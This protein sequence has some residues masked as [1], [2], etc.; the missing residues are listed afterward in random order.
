MKKILYT[1]NKLV[2]LFA[3]PA[4]LF[5]CNDY[6][7]EM[8]DNRTELDTPQKIT[9]ILVSAY[10]Q[11]LPVAMQELMSD[12]V[13]DYG[14]S[15]D[16]YRD[17]FQQSY[18]LQDVTDASFDTPTWVWE[19]NYKAV[20]SANHALEAIERL[21]GGDEL[22]AQKGEALLCRA[23]A[24]FTLCNTFC[25]AYNPESSGKDI[26]VPYVVEPETTVFVSRERGT[27]AEV[28]EKIAA[29]IEAGYPLLDDN[30]YTQPKYHFNKRAA[31]AF[32]AQFYL[33]YC[34]YDKSIEYANAAIG[35][36]PT[37]LFRNWDLYTG[38]SIAEYSNAYNATDEA[39]N[40]MNQGY[41]TISNRC[42]YYRY[43]HTQAM[44]TE[45]LRSRGP[46]GM[47]LPAYN[48]VYQ[49]SSR[50][51]FPAKM[52]EYFMYS[53]VAQGIGSPYRVLVAF[54][55]EKTLIDRAEAYAMSGG[56]QN[57]ELAARDLSYFYT[58][59]EAP[60]NLTASEIA[61]FYESGSTLY[62]KPLAPRFTVEP[63][64]QTNLVHACLHARR[65]VTLEEGGRL[66]DLKRYGIAYTHYVD[67]GTNIEVKPYDP[68]LAIQLPAT[69]I[70]AGMEANPR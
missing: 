63:G 27:V 18:L 24:H 70:A 26:G 20:S 8:P 52:A 13:T 1:A 30:N 11:S 29:D 6:L 9:Q 68:R 22:N 47:E 28:Y 38:T 57:F 3:G 31:A 35:E 32:A 12:N 61:S 7:D 62:A 54:N 55:V 45:T 34:K 67:A 60:S 5:S 37:A 33:Y 56:A 46:W 2:L 53:D 15:I 44:L 51:Y 25:Q 65:I 39:A 50:S 64:T 21:G 23:Y 58:S 36:N 17:I 41:N 16:I 43:I 19:Y 14:R 66:Q 42:K 48:I 40:F 59:A 49:S 10:S 4:L 69:V